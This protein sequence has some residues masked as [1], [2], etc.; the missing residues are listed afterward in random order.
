MKT[1]GLT[2]GIATGK[3]T[4]ARLLAEDGVPV[5]DADQAGRRVLAPGSEG[6]AEV[7][8]TFGD[9]LLSSDGALDRKALGRIVAE[10]PGAR[11]QLEA[12]THPRIA[13]AVLSD[14]QVH[15]EA[16]QPVAVVEAALMVETGSFRMY[17]AVL[18]VDAPRAVRIA[19]LR[20]REGWAPDEAARWIDLQMS[21]ADKEA[22]LR[23][24]EAQGGPAVV[25]IDND[26]DLDALRERTR[27]AW[28]R[29][30]ARVA[31]ALRT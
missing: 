19:R 25:R 30:L 18:L 31:P 27:A 13:A 21:L 4:V 12:I 22:E 10:D 20:A 16:G 29:L 6:L 7:I 8:A 14:L 2:G 26:G 3:S 15:A 5:V 17:D 23:Q 28:A 11:R 24:A 9:Q 1:I